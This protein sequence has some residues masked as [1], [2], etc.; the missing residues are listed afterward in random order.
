MELFLG[1]ITAIATATMAVFTMMQF[2]DLCRATVKKGN[3]LTNMGKQPVIITHIKAKGCTISNISYRNDGRGERVN[4]G[5]ESLPIDVMLC[6]GDEHSLAH[7]SVY[8]N[9]KEYIPLL[10]IRHNIKF[11]FDFNSMYVLATPY[12]AKV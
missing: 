4:S 1:I 6:N 3:I 11:P 12:R 7:I 5:K 2:Q 9:G 8:V 10:Q